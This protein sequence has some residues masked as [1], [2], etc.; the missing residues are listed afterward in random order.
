MASVD[1]STVSAHGS[2]RLRPKSSRGEGVD[3]ANGPRGK[4]G[5]RRPG[6]KAGAI[7]TGVIVGQAKKGV[8]IELGSTELLLPRSKYG[9]AGDWIEEAGYGAAVTVEVVADPGTTGGTGLTRVGIERSLRQPRGI[10]GRIERA[11]GGWRLIPADGTPAL[12]VIVLD[13]LDPDDLA[14]TTT[15]WDVGAAYRDDHRFVLPAD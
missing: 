9:S 8:L 14:R 13:H 2:P 11:G 3:V 5:G 6:P 1:D 4:G 7:V 12:P 15:R 10:D